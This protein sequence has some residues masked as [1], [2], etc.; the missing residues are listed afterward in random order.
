MID[1]Q[2]SHFRITGE[3][4]QGG[5]G[6]V[7][8]AIDEKLGRE[9]A[10]KVLLP[11]FLGDEERRHRFLQEARTAAKLNHPNIA[12]I[13]EVDEVDGQVFIAMELVEG[14]MLSTLIGNEPLTPEESVRL[15]LEISFGLA[16]AHSAQVVHRDL[17]PENVIITPDGHAKILDFG[18]AKTF[19][20]P[21][22]TS[23]GEDHSGDK[24]VSLNLTGEG[25]ILGTAAYMSPEQA[26]GQQVDTRSD[27]FSFGA[28]LYEMVA[29]K[30]PF[31]GDTVTDTLSAIIRD[32]QP[33]LVESAPEAPAELER[34]LG[35]C[36]EKNPSD[37][38]QHTDEISIDL[39]NLKRLTD[40]HSQS[41][42][43]VAHSDIAPGPAR[44]NG[45]AWLLGSLA[46]VVLAG[47]LVLPRLM[48][49]GSAAPVPAVT[50]LNSLA[51]LPFE[52]L[53]ETDGNDRVGQILQ[54]LII[55]DL[56]GGGALKVFSSQRLFDLQKQLGIS[57]A[58]TVD[59]SMATEVARMAGAGTML[60]GSLSRLGERWIMTGQLVDP[61]DGS[62]INS[63]RIDGEDLYAMVDT[64]TARIR[65]DLGVIHAAQQVGDLPAGEQSSQSMEAYNHYLAGVGHLNNMDYAVATEE[66]EKAVEIDPR[67]GQA[68][69]KLAIARWWSGS[70]NQAG[71]EFTGIVAGTSLQELL[72]SDLNLPARDRAL[73]E[74]FIPV[75]EYRYSD[76]IPL[77]RDLVKRYPDEKEA[78]YGLGEA[79]FHDSTDPESREWALK[80]FETAVRLDPSFR[81]A[82]RHIIDVYTMAQDFDTGIRK[83]GKF[84]KKDPTNPALPAALAGMLIANGEPQ[85]AEQVA[86][87]AMSDMD[88]PKARQF[89]LLTM[90]KAYRGEDM[91][92]QALETLN[93]GLNEP[94]DGHRSELLVL[95][96]L[97][98]IHSGELQAA[99]VVVDQVLELEPDHSDAFRILVDLDLAERNLQ[100]SMHTAKARLADNPTSVG[101]GQAWARSAIL[102]G[103]QDEIQE[104]MVKFREFQ[105]SPAIPTESKLKALVETAGAFNDVG[106]LTQ[107]RLLGAEALELAPDTFLPDVLRELA[108]VEV[109]VGGLDQA[110]SLYARLDET[111]REI[112]QSNLGRAWLAVLDGRFE[113][114]STLIRELA[115]KVSDPAERARW[116]LDIARRS[117]KVDQARST[118][119]YGL[120]QAGTDSS[121]RRLLVQAGLSW[122]AAGDDEGASN[123]FNR[124]LQLDTSHPLPEVHAW[125]AL[126]DLR[127]GHPAEAIDRIEAMERFSGNGPTPELILASAE[128]EL[129][130]PAQARTQLEEL[131]RTG[132]VTRET[133]RVLA[134]AHAA[135]NRWQ[136]A[137][138]AAEKAYAMS[139]SPPEAAVLAWILIAG[140]LD[141]T[142]GV[143]LA[144]AGVLAHDGYYHKVR[145]QPG[146][147]SV[148]HALALGLAKQ[149]K[150]AEARSVAIEA[151]RVSPRRPRFDAILENETR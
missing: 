46:V 101:A 2:I 94:G 149:G 47:A 82:Y 67:F 86:A 102:S 109:Q 49:P 80:S 50:I 122:M 139:G 81:L 131:I 36:L 75:V 19:E 33:P 96:A 41:L 140:D 137:R 114:A 120:E 78:W 6:V 18:L 31:R 35:K 17:K 27:V 100:N 147:P 127:T 65:D 5:M 108:L 37:R 64:L 52:N 73:V 24:T 103:N 34:I 72:D 62:I 22:H 63:V 95:Q 99:R 9:V 89:F 87:D 88:D 56:S 69:Y 14:Q 43:R 79:L 124:A 48:S 119:E 29:G 129:G 23:P 132:P 91:V 39:R 54:E 7:Y 58:R 115:S 45:R 4:G 13:H 3:L 59:R 20:L 26:R 93:R 51:V 121:R 32:P 98:E 53:S 30:N 71:G 42:P 145:V 16:K 76:A 85:R 90:A 142:E 113:A 123:L 135:E 11:D 74:A 84:L 105:E 40:S 10:L 83:I 141:T 57:D 143:R 28:M 126:C 38:Y 21:G 1:S 133:W 151:A 112:P 8:R 106:D 136:P 144:R 150:Q 61:E 68:I 92:D 118:L 125:A 107:A 66:L 104:F 138:T 130:R 25:R 70:V 55:T 134:M 111:G 117:G 110:R 44:W 60:T 77:L 148:L 116:E 15:G 97:L 128:L 12:T 146:S